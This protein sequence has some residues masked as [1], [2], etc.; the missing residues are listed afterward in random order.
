MVMSNNP[1]GDRP[2]PTAGAPDLEHV[3]IMCSAVNEIDSSALESLESINYRL[4]ESGVTLHL[5]EVKG[6][7]IDRLQRTHFLDELTGHV[8][9]SQF[10]AAGALDAGLAPHAAPAPTPRTLL[11]PA[12]T[13][14][15]PADGRPVSSC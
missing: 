4:R 10:A 5:S 1:N 11:E 12:P 2:Q 9:L 15:P 3:V 8:F 14:P 13:D 6:P 7:V